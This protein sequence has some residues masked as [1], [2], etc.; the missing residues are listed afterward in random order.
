MSVNNDFTGT[1]TTYR[2]PYSLADTDSY[3]YNCILGRSGLWYRDNLQVL[4]MYDRSR[5][6]V[7]QADY[8]RPPPS[9]WC[10]P[11]YDACSRATTVES[12]GHT[13]GESY[14]RCKGVAVV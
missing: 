14:Q 6:Y 5:P 12:E 8:D 9:Q 1:S 7:I 3:G 13:N 2:G 10:W 4:R 11:P